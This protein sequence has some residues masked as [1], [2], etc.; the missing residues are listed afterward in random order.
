MVSINISNFAYEGSTEISLGQKIR[1][2]NSDAA[3]HSATS[4][5]FD[6]GYISQ[7]DFV[8]IELDEVG[9][10]TYFC[11]LHVSMEGTI[12]V[13]NNSSTPTT[14]VPAYVYQPPV[15]DYGY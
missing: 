5:S 2:T 7:G 14:T 12:Q 1:F 10:Y 4:A 13:L 11:S 6:T 15:Y 9:T 3:I 8:E